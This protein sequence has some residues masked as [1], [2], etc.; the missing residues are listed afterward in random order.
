M[1]KTISLRPTADASGARLDSFLAAEIPELTRS[2]AQRLIEDGSVAVNGKVAAKSCRIAGGE[3]IMVSLPETEEVDVVA[4]DIP[5]DVVYEDADVIVVTKP[6]GL[7]VHP[8]PGHPDGTLVNALLHHCGS[9]LSGINGELRPGIV[10]RIDRDT[11]G[12]LIVAKNDRAHLALAAQL[13]DHS[14]YREYEAVVHGGFKEDEGT[15]DAPIGRHPTDR[16]RMAVLRDGGRD[17]VTHWS[18]VARYGPYTHIRCRLETGRTHQIRVHLSSIGHPL[19]GDEIYGGKPFPGLVGQCLHA[20][21]LTFAHPATGEL[22][23]VESP[24]PDWFT[25]ALVKV[26]RQYPQR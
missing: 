17:A 11:S 21:R 8:A 20:R 13:Q 5:L 14:L 23:T 26:E 1:T 10:H 9:S 18:V 2:A 24:L 15:V 25:A 19:V 4:Q 12:L 7:V 3:E 6:V 22:T 16:K